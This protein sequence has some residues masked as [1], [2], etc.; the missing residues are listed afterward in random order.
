MSPG[1]NAESAALLPPPPHRNAEWFTE[2]TL[3][4][5]VVETLYEA[6]GADETILNVVAAFETDR[7]IYATLNY[8]SGEIGYLVV[9]RDGGA[10]LDIGSGSW[11]DRYMLRQGPT[12]WTGPAPRPGGGK[13][14]SAKS[15]REAKTS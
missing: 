15:E 13:R 3:T 6:L 4:P 10:R 12:A 8:A 11:V 9:D 5:T 2:E 14:S 1:L 7:A